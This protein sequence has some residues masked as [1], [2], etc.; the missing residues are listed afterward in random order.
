MNNIKVTWDG[1]P[2]NEEFEKAEQFKNEFE[3]TFPGLIVE[4]I[5]SRPKDRG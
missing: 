2:T 1:E 4:L 5:G 3:A